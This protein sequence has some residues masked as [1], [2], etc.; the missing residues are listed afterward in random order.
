MPLTFGCA[1]SNTVSASSSRY[2][3]FVGLLSQLN[4]NY[5]PFSNDRCNGNSGYPPFFSSTSA[6][7]RLTCSV[8][9]SI[10]SSARS[11][12]RSRRSPRSRADAPPRSIAVIHPPTREGGSPFCQDLRDPEGVMGLSD[13][14]PNLIR[15][16]HLDHVADGIQAGPRTRSAP[17]SRSLWS[18][19]PK[20][21]PHFFT[22]YTRCTLPRPHRHGRLEFEHHPSPARPKSL[23]SL[24]PAMT[25]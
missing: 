20:T 24:S 19:G 23:F 21:S 18:D 6:V 25:G 2:R 1:L 8:R 13:E 4:S 16:M 15:M 11:C 14:S 22:A 17:R 5:L 3:P 9:A 7:S 10:F 12:V